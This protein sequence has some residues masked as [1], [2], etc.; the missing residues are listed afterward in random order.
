MQKPIPKSGLVHRHDAEVDL[1]MIQAARQRDAA[2]LD[3]GM[4]GTPVADKP[5][6]RILDYHWGGPDA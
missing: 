1:T 6:E 2:V 3:G 5:R 4:P